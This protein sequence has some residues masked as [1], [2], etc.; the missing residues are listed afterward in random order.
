MNEN[1]DERGRF[2]AA[3]SNMASLKSAWTA[4]GRSPTST[5]PYNPFRMQTREQLIAR[6]GPF[7]K[8]DLKSANPIVREMAAAQFKVP[9]APVKISGRR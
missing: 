4:N 7:I 1:H 2:A 3:D 5:D 8:K 9:F 6:G